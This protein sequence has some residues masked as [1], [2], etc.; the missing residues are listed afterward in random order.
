MKARTERIKGA[1]SGIPPAKPHDAG[2]PVRSIRYRRPKLYPKQEAALF[3]VARWSLIEATTKAG[4]TSG[5]IVWLGEKA[6]LGKQDRNYWWI[7]PIYSQAK[8]A[9][10][11]MLQ[12]IPREARTYNLAELR[13]DVINGTHVF[14]K[15]GEK[16]D[17]LYGEDVYAA[18]IDEASRM[19]EQSWHAIRTTL[20]ATGGPARII[21]NVKGRKNWFYKLA[22][23]AESGEPGWAYHKLT[24]RDATSAGIMD[25]AEIDDAR[26][27]LPDQVFRELYEAEPSD[28]GGNP[29]GLDAIARCR[30]ETQ[31]L[32]PVAAWGWDLGKHQDW[33]VGVALD[34]QGR[35]VKLVRFQAPWNETKRRIIAE[36]AGRPALVDATGVGDSIVED[37]TRASGNFEPFVF[38]A[39]SKQD[40][41]ELLSSAIQ[42]G[43]LGLTSAVLLS[44]LESFE[45]EYRGRDGR[46]TGVYYSAPEGMHDDCV[47][48]LA[49]AKRKLGIESGPFS[50]S[51]VDRSNGFS[52]S[53]ETD[54]ERIPGPDTDI[55]VRVMPGWDQ[56]S[57][58]I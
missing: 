1:S 21:G 49:L 31:S 30:M 36:T 7:A 58:L 47:C 18:V 4:K 19:K 17:S 26:S 16:P 35:E 37:L 11:R 54:G 56:K 43:H 3:D 33:T 23:K 22:R 13:I 40:L 32:H 45:Y 24:W 27:V 15:S 44:E 28:D 55:E 25:E 8:I 12:A 46:F 5:C 51:R 2:A 14:F 38:T 52:D 10:N 34:R 48:A 50:F 57:G 20:S 29:F 41:M 9:F 42:Q 6:I 39:R 53:M